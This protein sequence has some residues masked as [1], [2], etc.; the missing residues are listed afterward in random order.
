[1]SA[2][3]KYKICIFGDGG[4]G[5]TTLTQRYLTGVFKEKYQLTIGMDFYLK[6]LNLNGQ[7]VSLYIWDFAGEEKF[8]FLMSAALMGA[9][10]VIFVY[11]ITRYIT[12]K[13]LE[14]WF[15]VFAEAREKE[16]QDMIVVA[17]G[18]K[19]DLAEL[20]TIPKESGTELIDKYDLN[21]WIECSAKDGTNVERIFEELTQGLLEQESSRKK[22]KKV[23]FF[24]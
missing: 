3:K 21:G 8:R 23:I 24:D 16:S 12:L 22:N 2:T 6:K 11:D 18:S 17:V 20:R 1:M 10:A 7:E 5:K 13:N 19:L 15:S 14:N 9:H 4:V